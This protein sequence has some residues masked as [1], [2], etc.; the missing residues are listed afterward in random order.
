MTDTALAG[1]SVPAA[2]RRRTDTDLA[3][4]LLTTIRAH[5]GEWTTKRATHWLNTVDR[6]RARKALV[7]LTAQGALIEHQ[8]HGRRHFTLN[9]APK[10]SR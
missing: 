1:T 9:T 3:A 5:G 7:A 6:H 10:D 2:G 4:E 8:R